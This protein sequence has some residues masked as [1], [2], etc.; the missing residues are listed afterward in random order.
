MA[1]P[2]D[3]IAE[4]R[5]EERYVELERENDRFGDG[6]DVVWGVLPENK[7][8]PRGGKVEIQSLRFDSRSFSKADVT[9]WLDRHDLDYEFVMASG[10]DRTQSESDQEEERENPDWGKWVL[11]IGTSVI[12][13]ASLRSA[14]KASN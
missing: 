6:I 9:A 8:G 10:Q 1:Y 13:G 12:F 5:E 11:R 7:K 14:M 4:V 2:N 3:H